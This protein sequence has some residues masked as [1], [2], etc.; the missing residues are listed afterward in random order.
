MLL[1]ALSS[2]SI[3][4]AIK[5][6]QDLPAAL[7]SNANVAVLLGGDIFSLP[8]TVSSLKKTGKQV[9]VHADLMEGI[10]RDE[11]GVRYLAQRVKV[12][13]V[14]S[15]KASLVS[16]AQRA[17]LIAV[18]RLFVIDSTSL[19]TGARMIQSSSPDAVEVLPGVAL[20]YLH[21]RLAKMLG[22]PLIAGGLIE[23]V[24]EAQ[25]VLAA[26]ALAISTSSK[27]LWE[28]QDSI[29]N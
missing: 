14:V 29:Y 13:G 5:E 12:D 9:L 28:W 19:A 22:K 3:I 26:G 25:A 20:P 15:T 24:E 6:E 1:S 10:G 11:A 4:V 18:Q 7:R 16:A 17:G 21:G 2:K 23:T 27:E 8:L